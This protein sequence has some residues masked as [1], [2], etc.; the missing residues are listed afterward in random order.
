MN[1]FSA[2]FFL[3]KEKITIRGT[4]LWKFNSSLTKDQIYKTDIKKRIPIFSNE[5]KFLS[6]HQL[7]WEFLKY[8]V[9]EFNLKYTK[10]VAQEKL[11]LRTN[12]ENQ[13]EKLEIK[14][15]EDNLIKDDSVKN[16][17]D[18]I[19]EHITEGIR[20]RSKC[21]WYEHGEK[22]TIFYLV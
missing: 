8:E 17:L 6:K 11:Q 14:L 19:Y 20:I 10:H 1:H 2:L 3:S 4:G 16:E 5:H 9:R 21:D 15:D 7:R 13:L 12:S 22:S 18:E